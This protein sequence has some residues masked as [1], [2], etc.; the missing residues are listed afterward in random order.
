LASFTGEG[1]YCEGD[2]INSLFAEVSGTPD[3]TLE[4]TLDGNPMS[5]TSSSSNID[6]GNTAG[7]YVLIAL[8]DNSCDISLDETQTIIINATPDAP[9]VGEDASYCSNVVPEDIQASGSTGSYSWYSDASL[10]ELI[11]T[12]QSYTPNVIMGST[13]YYVTATE[14]GCE[15]LPAQVSITFENCEILIPTAFTPDND[16]INDTWELGD[17]DEIYP[18]NIVIVYNRW[19]NKVY[20]SD[21]GAYNQRQWNGTFNEQALPVASYYFIIEFNDNST[22]NKTGIVSIVK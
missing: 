10:S 6:L 8:T 13:T 16:Q 2:A 9:I 17:I 11:E 1:T 22:E 5:I 15:G 7:V 19:G 3:Y 20:E 14:N 18:K 12:T 4:Y 21:Q